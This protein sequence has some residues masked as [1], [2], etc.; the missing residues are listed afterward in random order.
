MAKLYLEC[1][2]GISGDMTAAALI[3][4]G[5]DREAILRALESLPLEGFRVEISTVEKSGLA[6]CDFDVQLDGVH[7]NHDHDMEWLFGDPGAP[8]HEDH[9]PAACEHHHSHRTLSDVYT[10]LDQGE[11][12]E[13]ARALAKKM[14]AILAQAEATV[15]GK[16]PDTVHFHEVGAVDSIVDIVARAVALDSLA[17]EEVIV[18]HL[19]E[20]QGSIRCQHG[21][22]PIPAPAVV[23]IA[24]EW[25][26]PLSVGSV[27][28][29][30]VTPTGASFVA[31]AR[32]ASELPETF[33]IQKVGMG[34]GK[35]TYAGTSGILRAFLIE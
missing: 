7:E 35:R 2:A 30:L 18:T 28:G 6:V 29:E 23:A 12:S 5:A 13:G 1:S 17:P 31:A 11:L 15:H 20:G 16:T 3:D 10:I 22:I 34:A 27:V 4:L 9:S 19:V 33:T 14:F 26:I 8:R 25:Q 32:S 24:Q 21:I